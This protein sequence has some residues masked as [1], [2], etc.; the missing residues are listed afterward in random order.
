MSLVEIYALDL[1]IDKVFRFLLTLFLSPIKEIQHPSGLAA[2]TF[3]NSNFLGAF[4]ALVTPIAFTV[5]VM[6]RRTMWPLLF[7][8]CLS[9][10]FASQARG[11]ILSVVPSLL[12]ALILTTRYPKGGAI[13]LTGLAVCGLL[14]FSLIER[15]TNRTYKQATKSAPPLSKVAFHLPSPK[16]LEIHVE[17][18]R[19][20]LI[21]N[22][23]DIRFDLAT[24]TNS[25]LTP[26][27]NGR[28]RL[29]DLINISFDYFQSM[30]MIIFH[31]LGRRSM[32]W[33]AT[34]KGWQVLDKNTLVDPESPPLNLEWLEDRWLSNR[35]YIWKRT[36]PLLDSFFGKGPGVFAVDFPQT[37][38]NGKI[39]TGF[40]WDALVIKPHNMYLQILHGGGILSLSLFLSLIWLSLKNKP[41][42]C[43]YVLALKSGILAFLGAGFF[44][45]LMPATGPIFWLMVGSL[46]GQ[47]SIK[48]SRE[49][50]PVE[51]LP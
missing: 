15:T 25:R 18:L 22:G 13:L 32:P 33:V 20:K 26:I 35:V 47:K 46:A 3:D 23:N 14:N 9:G 29:T 36:G 8:T 7:V 51:S 19:I 34:L 4:M 2:V 21:Q 30:P 38:Y 17:G 50:L 12:F 48:I 42:S 40:E 24:E 1:W 37:D 11:A 45:D 28:Y 16:E 27:G 43:P 31:D 10:L 39:N 49:L 41:G 5:A 44:Y 6:L